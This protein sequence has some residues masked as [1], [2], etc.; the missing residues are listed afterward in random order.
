MDRDA[1]LAGIDA[2]SCLAFLS[3]MVQ[4]RSYTETAGE[5]DLVRFMVQQMRTIGMD[6]HETPV[7][8]ERINAIGR[9]K[10]TG[11]GHSLLFN[12]HVDTNPATEGWTVDPWA[13]K[14][15][16]RFIY[17]IGV[18]NM[19]AGDAAYFC[20]VKTLVDAGVKLRG[21]IILTFVVGELQGGVGTV[22]FIDQGL[23]ADYFVNSEPT[24]LQAI[25]MHAG[26]GAFTIELT[27]DT[28]HLSKR[29]QAVD[30]LAIACELVPI[31]NA[32]TFSGALSAEHRSINRGHVGVL[33]AALGRELHEW[34]APQ[35][36]DFARLKGSAR[37][38]PGQTRE[39]VMEDL[40]GVLAAAEMR[41]R[42]LKALLIPRED[43][44][45]P[46]MPPFEVA[47]NA[48]IVQTVNAAYQHVRG[49]PQPTGAMAPPGF[50]GTDASHLLHRA[51][52]EGIVCGP[53]GRYNT[54]PDERVDIADFL[55]MIR[56]YLLTI[57][58]ICEIA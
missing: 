5:R 58:D 16:D 36:A 53:G 50:Y 20:A 40:R 47:R 3:R 14:V 1:L 23:R 54:M 34:R 48:R 8:G 26:G 56:I 49:E 44:D 29:E 27:G 25:T 22:A 21:D 46:S 39:G 31:I 42:G 33:H 52:M 13:G 57:C 2:P 45:R 18:S 12:G 6:A 15:D 9:L 32:M 41:H 35:V 28:R 43:A 51:G 19:K 55:D 7:E 37:Y 30:A 24:D 11:G 17:G 4:H 10:G 38:A